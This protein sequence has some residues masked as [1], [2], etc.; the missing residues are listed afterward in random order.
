M[1]DFHVKPNPVY[2]AI[3]PNEVLMAF[4]ELTAVGHIT[5]SVNKVPTEPISSQ[6]CGTV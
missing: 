1:P 2:G 4:D 3:H 6:T 5:C